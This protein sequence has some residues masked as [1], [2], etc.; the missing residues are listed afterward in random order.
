MGV[1]KI[2]RTNIKWLKS[3]WTRLGAEKSGFCVN[4]V[5]VA[6]FSY[7][8]VHEYKFV[9]LSRSFFVFEQEK[10]FLHEAFR[11]I[12]LFLSIGSRLSS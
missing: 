2:Q 10:F 1:C 5:K 4:R 9:L 6:I 12:A 7:C 8:K 11:G 3:V